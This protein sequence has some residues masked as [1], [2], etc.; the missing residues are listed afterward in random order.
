MIINAGRAMRVEVFWLA[1]V[2]SVIACCLSD[3]IG[4]FS[5]RDRSIV[6]RIDELRRT[7]LDLMIRIIRLENR[8]DANQIPQN[9]NTNIFQPPQQRTF[10][11]AVDDVL[12]KQGKIE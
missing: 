6:D 3:R 8:I 9:Q 7:E 11:D 5:F 1:L 2:G 10:Q 4:I 12:R